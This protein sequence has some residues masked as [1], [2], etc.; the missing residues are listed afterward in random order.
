MSKEPAEFIPKP[1]KEIVNAYTPGSFTTVPTAKV[2]FFRQCI[3]W[4]LIRFLMINLR[5]TI[6]ILK[7]HK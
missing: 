3:L 5:M 6:M 7:S 4:Q 1:E 2:R